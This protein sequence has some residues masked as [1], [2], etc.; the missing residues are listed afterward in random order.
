MSD[1]V[2]SASKVD[3]ERRFF[4]LLTFAIALVVLIGFARTFFLRGLFPEA[5]TY[6][7]PEPIFSIHGIFFTA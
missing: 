3:T 6:A 4:T 2:S 5:Q 7:A 1:T